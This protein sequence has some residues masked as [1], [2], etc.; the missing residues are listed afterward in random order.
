MTLKKFLA[1]ALLI[2]CIALI[3]CSGKKET[4]ASVARQWCDLNGKAYKAE[5]DAKKAA[6][7]AV[8]KFEKKIESK[9]GSDRAFM[10]QVD[11]EVEKCEDA[12][13]GR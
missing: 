7:E 5:G 2:L 10:K 3:S 11:E 13:E 4:P 12:S 1:P 6:E 8:E 9:Y